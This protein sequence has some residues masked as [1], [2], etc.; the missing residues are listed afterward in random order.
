MDIIRGSLKNPVSRFMVAIG[1]ILLGIIAFSSLAIDLFPEITYPIASVVTEYSG[2]SPQDVEMTITRPIEKRLSRIQN[3]RHVSSRSREGVSIVTVEF[4]WGTNLDVA[5]F[6]IQQSVSQIQDLFPDEARLPVI[7]KFDP[8][9]ISVIVLSIT[10]P[11]DEFR[12]RELAEDFVAPRLESLKGVASANVF[13]GLTRE[14]QVELE[15]SKLERMNLSL[16]RVA[17]AVRAAH[18]DK[19]GGSLRTEK[20][21]FSIR[22]LGRTPEVS[23]LEEIVVH[24]QNGVSIRLKDIGRIKDGYEDTQTEVNVN[25][26]RGIVI[27]VQKQI[28]GNTVSVVD[29]TLK[30]LT[31]IR[32]E[33][34]PGVSIEVVSDQS[35]FIRKSIKNLQKE[36]MMGA[37]LAVAII[38]LF[39]RNV[40]STLIIAHAIPV[41]IIATFVLLHFGKFTLNIMT[42]G[43]LALGV[44]RLVDDAIV[45]LE[46]INRHMESGE[47]P[48]EASY[49]GTTE[50]SKPVIA[51][52]LTSIIVFLPLAFVTGIAPILFIQLAYTV[53]FS[54]LASLFVS[55]TLVPILTNKFLRPTRLTAKPSRVQRILQKAYPLFVWMDQRYH[56]T[57]DFALSHRKLVVTGVVAVFL[58]TLLLIPLMGT[59]LFPPSDEGQVRMSIRLPVGSSLEETKRV[60]DQVEEIVFDEVPELKSLWAR[61]GSGRGRSVIFGGRFAGPHTGMASLML[62]DQS[63]RKRSAETIARRLRERV[64]HIP[65]SKITVFPGGIISR[66][67]TFGADEP[68]D[69]EILGYDLATGSRLAREV[70][71][72]LREVGGVTDIQISREE[73]L[74]EYQVQLRQDRL[75]ALGLTTSRVG[76]IVRG[77]IEGMEAAI[78]VDPM[79][80]REHYVRVRLREEDRR[81]PEDLARLPLPALDGKVV[82]LENVA[83][84]VRTTSPVQLE[85]K[86][87]QRIVHVTANTSGRDLGSIASEI[88]KKI[89]RMDVPEG[90]SVLLK[91]ARLEQ[92]EAF[93]TLLFSVGLAIFLVYMVL[94]SQ[95]ASL[96]H[97]FLVMFSVPLGLIG[98]LWALFVT[99]NTLNMV[100]FIGI[101]MMVGIVVNN[102][103]ILVDFINRLRNVEGVPLREAIIRGGRVRLRPILM[104]SFTTILG[105]MPMALGLGEGAEAYTSLA[106]AV[107]GGLIVSM[108]LTLVFIPTIYF[109]VE[110]RR[111]RKKGI[112]G[113]RVQGVEV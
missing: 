14:I 78:Y 77:A 91:G 30:A 20:Q 86:Y 39:L 70:E 105:L 84:V 31:Q 15:R 24:R 95:F 25:R 44:G 43:G 52:S 21:E 107:I 28:G 110:E 109:I 97:P 11:M 108:F 73:G 67:I 103:I 96:L 71:G 4:Y 34:P 26:V 88:E 40:T 53:A 58:G 32:K 75:A 100:S 7:I 55:L 16:D 38:L 35:T 111:S 72:I 82:P 112:Q 47:P 87:Q 76:E 8:S 113:S 106:I 10:G 93:Q 9:Q 89:S 83:E 42:L 59:E 6:D 33:L 101:I 94:A 63:E 102:A 57:L 79:T 23:D 66:V 45:V 56:H 51:A 3:V 48:E 18:M 60:M 36:A 2:A 65:G 85:R 27:G 29:H 17:Q 74:P 12:L 37:L 80:G 64:N 99:G 90:F 13:G 68:I 98:V 62:V 49:Q 81:R 61:A 69:V 54:L 22:T 19:P 41:S 1:I 46:N 5:S 104:T 50:V 92:K